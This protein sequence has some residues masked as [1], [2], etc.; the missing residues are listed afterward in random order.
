MMSRADAATAAGAAAGLRDGRRTRLGAGTLCGEDRKFFSQ[1]LRAAMRALD[2]AL[3]FNRAH[4]RLKILFTFATGKLIK[5]HCILPSKNYCG[6]ASKSCFISGLGSLR[7][8]CICRI[9]LSVMPLWKGIPR[10]GWV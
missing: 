10:M 2:S 1:F 6:V 3:P 4:E 5:R 7:G 8:A 9:W